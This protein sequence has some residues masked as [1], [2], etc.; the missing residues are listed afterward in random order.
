VLDGTASVHVGFCRS[1]KCSLG[2]IYSCNPGSSIEE[3]RA[4][5]RRLQ[6]NGAVVLMAATLMLSL[7]WNIYLLVG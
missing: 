2:V 7:F 5:K 4:R 6:I 3:A 1:P